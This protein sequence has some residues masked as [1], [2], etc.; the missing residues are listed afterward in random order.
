LS[1]L[2]YLKEHYR[3]FFSFQMVAWSGTVVNLILLWLLHGV[4]GIHLLLAGAIAIEFSIIWNFTFYYY[5]T[6]GERRR[7]GARHFLRQLI[8]FNA[9]T[10]FIDLAVRLTVLWFMVEVAGIHYLLADMIGMTIAPLF[11]Y[12]ANEHYIFQRLRDPV[13]EQI[14]DL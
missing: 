5:V 1:Y 3:R 12:Y 6:W 10:V 2:N 9:V 7:R 8:R 14:H 11:K 4:L 13:A